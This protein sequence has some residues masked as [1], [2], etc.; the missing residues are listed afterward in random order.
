MTFPPNP[1]NYGDETSLNRQMMQQDY[2]ANQERFREAPDDPK[3]KRRKQRLLQAGWK[4]DG[5]LWTNPRFPGTHN[6]SSAEL[7]EMGFLDTAQ[8]GDQ[9]SG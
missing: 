6:I 2:D 8:E 5:L 7:H 3:T 9:K 4:F 1:E